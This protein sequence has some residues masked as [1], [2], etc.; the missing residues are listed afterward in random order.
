MSLPNSVQDAVHN[1]VELFMFNAMHGLFQFLK[2]SGW[3]MAQ[4]FVFMQLYKGGPATI[5]DL[6]T[7]LGVTKAAMS[8]MIDGLVRQGIATRTEVAHDRR[9]TQVALT[10]HGRLI[11]EQC[12]AARY[13]WLQDVPELT[14]HQQQ[15]II[16]GLEELTRVVQHLEPAEGR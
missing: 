4:Y 6:A 9:F 14:V 11:T 1:W 3:S 5:S 15:V 8:Q 16:A 13:Q 12:I 10:D 2:T 7:F